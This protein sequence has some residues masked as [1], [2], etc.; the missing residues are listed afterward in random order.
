VQ[1][2]FAKGVED[3]RKTIGLDSNLPVVC[4]RNF[5]EDGSLLPCKLGLLRDPFDYPSGVSLCVCE[6]EREEMEREREGEGEGLMEGERGGGRRGGGGQVCVCV[7]HAM[8]VCVCVCGNC[9]N[10][11]VYSRDFPKIYSILKRFSGPC[12]TSVSTP[13]LKWVLCVR[14]RAC[15]SVVPPSS[16]TLP[17]ANPGILA[18]MCECLLT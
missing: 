3:F 4:L 17:T 12:Q 14:A 6:R 7:C 2:D 16:F 11:G 10:L 18:R 15:V 5:S 1:G 8:C 13:T 9:R